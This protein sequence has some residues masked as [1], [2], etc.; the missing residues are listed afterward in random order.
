MKHVAIVDYGAGNLDSVARAI[1]ECGGD[2]HVTDQAADIRAASYV[3]LPG[4]G[5]FGDGMRNLRARGL[6]VILAEEVRDKQIPLLG[7]CLGMQL[8][9]RQGTEGAPVE[10]LGWFDAT[11]LRLV[12]DA[13]STRI[14][15]VG[16][17]EVALSRSTPLFDGVPSDSDFYFVHS[18]HVVCDDP[19]D[20]VG[21]TPYCQ[22]FVSAIGR[23]NLLGVQ[24]HPEKSQR[25]GLRVLQNFLA[26]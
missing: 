9:A 2:A 16:W 13:P 25:L 11:V 10:G 17:N 15:H 7:I 14:P 24:F 23:G 3:I 21:T 6:D 8:L 20:V 22:G 19:A 18:Y 12:P 4:V 26:L 5:A 1:E